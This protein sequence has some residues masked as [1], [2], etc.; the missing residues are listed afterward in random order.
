NRAGVAALAD[1]SAIGSSEQLELK[2]PDF[3]A[4]RGR[5]DFQKLIADLKVKAE[6]SSKNPSSPAKK[7]SGCPGGGLGHGLTPYLV[8][9]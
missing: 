9:I 2:E 5:A 7:Q 3:D 6:K 1:A 8:P 4:V